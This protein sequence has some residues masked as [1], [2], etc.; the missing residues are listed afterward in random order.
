MVLDNIKK[1]YLQARKDRDS[2]K[3]GVLSTLIGDIEKIGK[4]AGNR[5]PK[6][7]ESIITI[8]KFIKCIDQTLKLSN[9]NSDVLLKE[10]ELLNSFL[11]DMMSEIELKEVIRGIVLRLRQDPE[12]T[13]SIVVGTVMREL[14]ANYNNYDGKLASEIVRAELS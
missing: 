4:D 8:R 3:I 9:R 1:T 13:K 11:P 7:D 6:D 14:K 12:N 5:E 10:K 2:F